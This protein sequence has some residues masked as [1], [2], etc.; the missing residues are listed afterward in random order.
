MAV[1]IAKDAASRITVIRFFFF[2]ESVSRIREAYHDADNV[3][4]GFISPLIC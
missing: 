2:I 3:N 1:P 4:G